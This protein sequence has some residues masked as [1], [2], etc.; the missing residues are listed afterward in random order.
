MAQL[1]LYLFHSL[2]SPNNFLLKIFVLMSPLLETSCPPH[3]P[4]EIGPSLQYPVCF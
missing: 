1:Q 3:L 2:F 4:M